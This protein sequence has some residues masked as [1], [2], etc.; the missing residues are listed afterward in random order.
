MKTKNTTQLQLQ[1]IKEMRDEASRGSGGIL[2]KTHRFRSFQICH[3][4]SIA[5]VKIIEPQNST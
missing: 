2:S 1:K 3:K 5:R 4:V